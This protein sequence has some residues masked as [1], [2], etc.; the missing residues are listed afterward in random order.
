VNQTDSAVVTT[1]ES[2]EVIIVTTPEPT[3][4]LAIATTTTIAETTTESKVVSTTT[5]SNVVATP[6]AII[7]NDVSG[8]AGT[9]TGTATKTNH[10]IVIKSTV[11]S[12]TWSSELKDKNSEQ[13]KKEYQ[14][15]C[16]AWK[17]KEGD[18]LI[19]CVVRSFSEPTS[20]ARKRRSGSVVVDAILTLSKTVQPT[21]D[22]LSP[23][24]GHTITSVSSSTS[25]DGCQANSSLQTTGAIQQ[26]VCNAGFVDRGNDCVSSGFNLSMSLGLVLVVLIK[27]LF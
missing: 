23:P 22:T 10:I 19:S 24:A 18:D 25:T 17:Q 12:I 4:K 13:F 5:E 11:S 14:A 6:T 15:Y 3:T 20:S 16:D 9:G 8:S 21:K 1:T 27:Q 2:E 26:C 7:I